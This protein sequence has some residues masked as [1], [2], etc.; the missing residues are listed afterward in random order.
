[1]A[2]RSQTSRIVI[3]ALLAI[4][5]VGLAYWLYVS[6]TEPW[7]TV[8]RQEA[9]TSATRGRMDDIRTALVHYE[10]KYNR[11]PLTLDSL[12]TFVRQDSAITARADSLFGAGF[13][14]DSLLYS[15]RSGKPFEYAVN[16]TA[17]V[18]MYRLKD[19]D[20]ADQIGTLE[21]DPTRLNTAT[22]E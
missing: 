7:E 11:F 10:N 20:T 13:Q 17:R 22:W 5:I 4:V 18:R 19:P 9:L 12:V 16:D 6:I 1:M 3:Q 8:E 2:S 21:P 15:P 14:P